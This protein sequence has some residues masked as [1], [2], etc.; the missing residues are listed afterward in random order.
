MRRDSIFW[1]VILVVM[2]GLFLLENLG[3][4]PRGINVWEIFWPLLLI[5]LGVN[6]LLGAV[7]RRGGTVDAET[8]HLPLD[9]AQ[10]AWVKLV[11][12]AGELRIDDRAAPGELLNGSF[13]GGVE[14]TSRRVGNEVQLELR[15]P[16]GNFPGVFPFDGQDRLNWTVGLNPEIP[17]R[18]ELEVGASRSRLDLSRMQI[19]ELRISTGASATEI[20]FPERAGMTQAWIHSGAASVEAEIPSG[21]SARIH[22]GGALS[23]IHVDTARFPQMGGD[24]QSPD[25]ATAENRLNLDFETGVGSITVR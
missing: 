22:V 10:Q 25:Y 16:V 9:G 13:G 8:L 5:G 15:L 12:G 18:L 11:H 7:N 23:G 4:L 20:R 24:Y 21:V 6:A 1:G 19:K 14:K 3:F 2:G 17:L